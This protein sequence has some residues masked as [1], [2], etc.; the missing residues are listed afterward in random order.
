MS[1]LGHICCNIWM[2]SGVD[3]IKSAF[4]L[5]LCGL[6]GAALMGCSDGAAQD[7]V[8]SKEGVSPTASTVEY[9]PQITNKSLLSCKS[10]ECAFYLTTEVAD[11]TNN[12]VYQHRQRLN[13]TP[14]LKAI[15]NVGLARFEK[16]HNV[17]ENTMFMLDRDV[18]KQLP[19]FENVWL[20]DTRSLSETGPKPTLE[21]LPFYYRL[22]YK[23]REHVF[24]GIYSKSEDNQ[25]G[26]DMGTIDSSG[27]YI[28]IRS[29]GDSAAYDALSSMSQYCDSICQ[30]L[31][32]GLDDAMGINAD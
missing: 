13:I 23:D 19:E 16:L 21:L 15:E 9:V 17:S 2:C 22:E 25:F 10:S 3:V 11:E 5:G 24:V 20:Y 28:R 18:V 32:N 6:I 12:R 14:I 26:L 4:E 7:Q 30:I 1:T 29:A 31:R 27:R 8:E